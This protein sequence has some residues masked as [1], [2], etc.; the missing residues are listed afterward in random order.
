MTQVL[1]STLFN[2]INNFEIS[3]SGAS[4]TFT[5]R[6][7]RENGWSMPYAERVFSEYKKFLFMMA[8]SYK[9]ITPSDQIDQAWHLHLSYTK[10][11][12]QELCSEIVGKPLHHN[13]TRGGTSEDKRYRDQYEQ[14]LAYY[15][16]IFNQDPPAD[17]WPAISLRFN[18]EDLFVRVN[19]RVMWTIAKPQIS[20][21]KLLIIGSFTLGLAACSSF[22]DAT[23]FWFWIKAAIGGYIVYR[24]VKW[25]LS[26]RGGG[27]G[28]YSG[29]GSLGGCGGG[30][31]SSGCSSGGCGSGCGGGGCGS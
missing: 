25:I 13:P 7:A 11:Y 31:N 3:D 28:G 6:L 17:I 21:W 26:D 19:R 18:E 22:G 4:L 14:T 23:D 8:T 20:A 5:A 12:W 27:G 24:I 1:N 9:P 10:S 16:S 29:C 15:K 2:R 30:G